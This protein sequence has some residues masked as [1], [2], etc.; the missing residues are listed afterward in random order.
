MI[1]VTEQSDHRF[2]VRVEGET[3]E[4]TAQ[5]EYIK[6]VFGKNPP[7]PTDIVRASFEFLLERESVDDI[8]KEFDL[9]VIETYF[10]EYPTVIKR[11][12]S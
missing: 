9:S 1:A 12:V 7:A 4:V 11:I 6:E 8:L 10:P 5:P 3:F 2:A